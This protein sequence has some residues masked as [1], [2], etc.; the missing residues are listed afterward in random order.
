MFLHENFWKRSNFLWKK[1]RQMYVINFKEKMKFSEKRPNFYTVIMY[2]IN[3]SEE[4]RTFWNKLCPNVCC[5]FWQKQFWKKTLYVM[6]W[7]KVKIFV[8]CQNFF[9]K[10]FIYEP[11]S[12][13]T[14]QNN[15]SIL[16]THSRKTNEK[17]RCT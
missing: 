4:S 13:Y 12:V 7:E 11:F 15:R 8:K 14:T 3:F 5:Q 9:V 10:H 16:P 1:T 17:W 2:V 6:N